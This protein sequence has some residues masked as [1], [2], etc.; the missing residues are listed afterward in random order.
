MCSIYLPKNY[1]YN[2]RFKLIL[3][4]NNRLFH[5]IGFTKKDVEFAVIK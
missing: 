2:I 4:S 5:G 1:Q 3:C